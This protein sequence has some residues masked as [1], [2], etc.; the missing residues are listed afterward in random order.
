[1]PLAVI[2][3]EFDPLVEIAGLTVRWETLAIAGAVL[4]G[5][6][7]AALLAHRDRSAPDD[8]LRLDDM[9]FVLVA[10]VPGAVVGGR[11]GYLLIHLD[12]FQANPDRILDPSSGGLELGLSVVGG[13]LAGVLVGHLLG[14]PL[15]RW[16]HVAAVPLLLVLGLGKAA[17][18]LGGTGQGEPSVIDW[19]TAYLGPGPWGSLAPEIPSHPAQAYEAAAAGIALLDLLVIAFLLAPFRRDGRLLFGALA[20][21]AVG[22]FVAGLWWRDPATLGPLSTAQVIALGIAAGSIVV[23]LGLAWR[24]RKGPWTASGDQEATGPFDGGVQWPDEE[25]A[26]RWRSD[27]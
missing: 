1:M 12:Y 20:L 8:P 19:A 18:I 21:W 16:L 7:L 15:G 4:V 11:I 24:G 3:F 25:A 26:R 13:L 9:L 23:L 17:N 22:R 10:I 6:L 14:L 5:L 27:P 2:T